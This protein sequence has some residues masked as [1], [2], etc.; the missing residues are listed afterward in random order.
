MPTDSWDVT[1]G[2]P[3]GLAKAEPV[4]IREM[5]SRLA[6]RQWIYC[7]SYHYGLNWTHVWAKFVGGANNEVI[8]QYSAGARDRFTVRPVVL[9]DTNRPDSP[10]GT[11]PAESVFR[12]LRNAGRTDHPRILRFSPEP[13]WIEEREY[14]YYPKLPA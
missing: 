7:Y 14:P 13:R 2:F 11:G 3:S 4:S 8:V 6:S 5:I 10:H 9:F 1:P 12:V